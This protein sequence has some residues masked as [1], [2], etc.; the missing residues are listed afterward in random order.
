MANIFVSYKYADSDVYPIRNKGF[1]TTARDYVDEIE[2]RFKAIGQ[3]YRGEHKDEDLSGYSDD[4][5]W[6]H[7]KDKIFNTTVTVVLM[8]PNMKNPNS[9]D[10]SQWI[11]WEIYYSLRK[12]TR[13]DRQSQRNA[14]L[15]VILPDSSGSYAYAK[16]SRSCCTAGCNL[17]HTEKFFT[18]IRNNMFNRN[19]KVKANCIKGD[20][21]YYG[22]ASYINL[23]TWQEFIADINS[24]LENSLRIKNLFSDD[25]LYINVNKS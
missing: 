4:Y 15:A 24:Q 16:E 11:P 18:I 9:Y 7:L 25:E 8:S 19:S 21:V 1:W 22:D 12:T 5:I 23:I 14:V 3:V 20:N 6:E 10:Y 17:W 13:G 2:E